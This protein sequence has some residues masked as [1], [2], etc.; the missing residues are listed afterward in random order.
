[1]SPADDEWSVLMR[2][3]LGGDARAY[4]RFLADVTPVLRAVVRARS[5]DLAWDQQE[6]IVQEVLLALHRKR[7]TWQPDLPIR[8][9]LYAVARHKT[10]DAF[11][12]RGSAVHLQI[13]DFEN[14]LAAD[15]P[16]DGLAARDVAFL[17]GRLDRRSAE[18]VRSVGID[19]EPALAVGERLGLTEGAVRVVLHRAI[20]RMAAIAKGPRA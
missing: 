14:V 5:R 6:D 2:A 1:M 17:I 18:I 4:A 11:R 19:E 9:W 12:A 15:E 3:A 13:D 10:V 16:A 7:H 20:K 8:P